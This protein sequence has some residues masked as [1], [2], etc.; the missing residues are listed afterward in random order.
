MH[1]GGLHR[2][3]H[4]PLASPI[5]LRDMGCMHEHEHMSFNLNRFHQPLASPKQLPACSNLTVAGGEKESKRR[6]VTWVAHEHMSFNLN[7]SHA[8]TER[9]CSSWRTRGQVDCTGMGGAY[10][11]PV[12]ATRTVTT[13]IG[14]NGNCCVKYNDSKKMWRDS[15]IIIMKTPYCIGTL[16]ALFLHLLLPFETEDE[17]TVGENVK[18]SGEANM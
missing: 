8:G 2:S 1:G 17:D 13:C 16:L 18:E 10:T 4:Q 7:R 3:L 5:D 9:V 14:N 11:A 6:V 15:L 12:T